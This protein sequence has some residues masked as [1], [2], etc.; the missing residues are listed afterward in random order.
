[1]KGSNYLALKAYFGFLHSIFIAKA[2]VRVEC[3][4]GAS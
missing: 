4:T 3:D 1:M 2:T